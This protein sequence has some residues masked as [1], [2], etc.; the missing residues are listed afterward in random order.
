MNPFLSR[1]RILLEGIMPERALL[2]LRREKIPLY[3]VKK[4]QK[5]QILF[6]ISKKDS[7]KVFA[8]YPN[9]CYNNAVYSPFVL[10]KVGERGLSRYVEMAKKR[11]GMLVGMLAGLIVLLAAD[12]FVF[13]VEFVGS[14]VYKREA[15]S[16]LE[17][18]GITPFAPYPKGKED[19]ACAQLLVISDV[20]YCSIKK[21][22]GYVYVEMRI[23][24][25]SKESVQTESMRAKHTGKVYALAVLRGES[26]VE[27]GQEVNVGDVLVENVFLMEDGGQVRV[28]PIA[29]VVI[30]CIYEKEIEAETADEAFA[31]AYLELDVSDK[32]RILEKT[33]EKTDGER[34]LFHV[35]IR[36]MAIETVNM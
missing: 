9:V 6:S 15:L 5:T 19:W 12:S 27:I 4:V 10:K 25:F 32:D 36:Y 21:S 24:P 26:R 13:G 22:G 14:A 11:I 1:E 17:Q 28:E 31:S 29:K 33:V 7:E 8:I 2:R 20:E 18:S 16:V 3:D 35:K 30:E 23:S 34:S